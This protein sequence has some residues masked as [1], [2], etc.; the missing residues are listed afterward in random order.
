MAAV[1]LVVLAMV[2]LG[3]SGSE[4]AE[5]P[6]DGDGAPTSIIAEAEGGEV[7][8]A[9]VA[10]MMDAAV[11]EQG[12]EGAGLVIVERDDGVV[13][14]HYSGDFEADR[15]SL[16]ASSSKMLTAGVL[17]HL[18]DEGTLDLDAPV[19]D[20]VDWER[21]IRTSPRRSCC[22]TAPGWSG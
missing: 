10:A 6:N 5:D 8:F 12:L 15:I 19:S 21:A 22:R 2:G 1:G 9:E 3:C 7:D 17:L 20:V 14:E 13:Y 11:A 18:A 4:S 16:L